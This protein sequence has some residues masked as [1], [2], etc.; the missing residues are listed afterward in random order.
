MKHIRRYQRMQEWELANRTLKMGELVT[1]AELPE[2]KLEE[3]LD[4]LAKE[5]REG[6]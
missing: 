2:W 3:E 4:R 5:H 1:L 6:K